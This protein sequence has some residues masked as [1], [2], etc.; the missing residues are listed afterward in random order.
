MDGARGAGW[1]LRYYVRPGAELLDGA[2]APVLE[3]AHQPAEHVRGGARIGQRAVARRRPRAEEPGLRPQL[4]VR[5]LVRLH[6]PP[7]PYARLAH[8]D[9]GPRTP[10]SYDT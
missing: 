9:V 3:P 2:D 5:H 6:L 10:A 4:A 8:G 1:R 7:G